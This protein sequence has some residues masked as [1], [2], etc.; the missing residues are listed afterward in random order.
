MKRI[1]GAGHVG[2]RFV[3]EDVATSR[4]PTEITA[5]WLNGLQEEVCNVIVGAGLV[6]NGGSETQL[7]DAIIAMIGSGAAGAT[8]A[9]TL[10]GYDSTQFWRND[11][12]VFNTADQGYYQFPPDASGRRIIH[13]WGPLAAVGGNQNITFGTP[14]PNALLSIVPSIDSDTDDATL[15][16]AFVRNRTRLGFQL[17]AGGINMRG[18]TYFAVGW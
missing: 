1:D 5:S 8:N 9:D 16:K 6:L 17:F 11:A 3:S 12:V 18:G 4:P 14:F 10:D 13:Q 2:G 7:R 15:F